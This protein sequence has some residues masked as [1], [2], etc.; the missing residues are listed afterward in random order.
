MNG[1]A[2]S[3][4]AKCNQ[5]NY[6]LTELLTSVPVIINLSLLSTSFSSVRIYL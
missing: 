6:A 5:L 4:E 1:E 2:A 3:S